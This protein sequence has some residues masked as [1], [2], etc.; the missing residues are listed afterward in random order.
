[1]KRRTHNAQR[2]KLRARRTGMS[3]WRRW[4]KVKYQYRWQAPWKRAAKSEGAS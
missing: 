3:L 4:D 1:M 2:K